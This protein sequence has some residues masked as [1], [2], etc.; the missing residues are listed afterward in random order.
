MARDGKGVDGLAIDP[1]VSVFT[2]GVLLKGVWANGLKFS[3]CT[4]NDRFVT[5][6]LLS[7]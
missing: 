5:S 2:K 6:E 1:L 4:P 3:I 7:L